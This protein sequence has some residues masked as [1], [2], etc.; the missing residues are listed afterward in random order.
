MSRRARHQSTVTVA[1]IEPPRAVI[2]VEHSFN[3]DEAVHLLSAW[4]VD[5]GY[6]TF[7]PL[8][9]DEEVR[10]ALRLQFREQGGLDYF[11]A[12]RNDIE[13]EMADEIRVW[14]TEH[15][16]RVWPELTHEGQQP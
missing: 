4:Y 5:V 14:A 7:D 3:R 9:A 1:S 13:S 12:E 15:V 11:W 10:D 8:V 16:D 2:A 6:Q